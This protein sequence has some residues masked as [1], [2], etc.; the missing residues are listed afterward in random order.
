MLRRLP[1]QATYAQ[2]HGDFGVQ[3]ISGSDLGYALLWL[4]TLFGLAITWTTV[5]LYRMGQ[6]S[7]GD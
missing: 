4:L 1:V 7:F 3:A 5:S 2:Y 6:Q